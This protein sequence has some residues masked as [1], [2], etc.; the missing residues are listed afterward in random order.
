VHPVPRSF[1]RAVTAA[2]GTALLTA[3]LLTTAL[4]TA[5]IMPGPSR[6]AA[7][8]RAPQASQTSQASAAHASYAIGDAYVVGVSAGGFMATQ[9]HIAH[10]ATFQ[11]VGIFTAG[12][13]HCARG[14]LTT[15]QLACMSG[16][17][18]R[19]LPGLVQIT[20]ERSAQGS[21][22]DAANLAGDPVYV[23]H[24]SSDRTVVRAVNDDLAAYYRDL[25]GRVAYD[26]TTAAGHA[27]VS[28]LGPV[29][30]QST[31]S[32]YINDCGTDPEGAMLGHLFGAVNPPNTGEPAGTVQAFDQNA[33]AP[34]GSAAAVSMGGTGY[35]YVPE[36]CASGA[37][38]RLV[39]ALHGCQQSAS[40]IGTTFVE[41]AFLNQYAD[42]NETIVL[43]PQAAPDP[44]RG[45]PLGCWDWWGYLGTTGYDTRGAPQIETIMRMVRAL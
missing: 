32:P 23:F 39:V 4:L 10:S 21:I 36:A 6:S 38:C 19:D 34:G 3:A 41:R 14:S 33:F 45:N 40:A 7:A 27:W 42:T 26:T 18:G 20:R 9:L 30:C 44:A 2:P 5:A 16:V 28:P 22:D 25:G 29:A 43:Y 17:Q 1:R 35:R 11:G 8:A 15:A 24:G 31:L 13:Y 12:P 37:S